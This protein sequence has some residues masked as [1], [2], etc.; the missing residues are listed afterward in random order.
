MRTVYSGEPF[1]DS[2][3]KSLFLAGP[4][5]R[6]SEVRS[7]RPG[8]LR[9]LQGCGYDGVV[10]VPE[11]RD[12]SQ[13]AGSYEDY[14]DWEHKGLNVADCIIFW[15]PRD[16]KNL[17]G[18]T[19]NVEFG[20]FAKSGKIILG[21]PPGAEKVRYLAFTAEKFWIPRF[22]TLEETIAAAVKFVGEG[23]FRSGGECQVPLIIWNTSTFQKWL[24]AQTAAGNRL[25]GAKVEWLLR[26]RKKPDYALV[27]L[28]HVDVYVAQ[29]NRNKNNEIIVSRPDISTLI[30]YKK[31]ID[32]LRTK[33]VLIREFRSAAAT[34]DGFIWEFPGGSSWKEGTSPAEVAIEE[35]A[36]ET[37]LK[38]EADRITF[39]G[40]RQLA[41]TLSLHKANIFSVELTEEEFG[42]LEG[43]KGRVH[44]T[45]ADGKDPS[46]ERTYIE[47]K[48]AEEILKENLVDW[49]TLGM[50]FSVLSEQI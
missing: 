30:M 26:L 7:W 49:G 43:Q 41:G 38:I 36:E 24:R 47:V 35:A 13:P 20:L 1:P 14:A 5:P 23:A 21:F 19:T 9:I 4:T 45:G 42:W 28:M 16:L 33:I 48:T 6:S 2:W 39:H 3:T 25:D 50:I 11:N 44:G 32:F 29:E 18:F 10:F 15:I 27:W 37:G 40:S 34:S 46:G 12:G 17:P 22:S 8:A 31:G